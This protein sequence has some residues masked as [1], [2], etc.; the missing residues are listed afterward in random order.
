[1]ASGTL[2]TSLRPSI[3]AVRDCRCRRK[4]NYTF[5]IRAKKMTGWELGSPSVAPLSRL[6]MDASGRQRMMVTELH[7]RLLSLVDT[8]V[9]RTPNLVAIGLIRHRTRH[10]HPVRII[11]P[12]QYQGT[13]DVPLRTGAL[14]LSW[15]PMKEGAPVSVYSYP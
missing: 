14:F 7:F 11:R 10:D 5:G 2:S 6:I 4:S 8:R 9:W 15:S 13:I 1:L 12:K 3:T